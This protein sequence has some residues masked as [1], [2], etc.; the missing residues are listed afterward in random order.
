MANFAMREILQERMKLVGGITGDPTGNDAM[1][2]A[3]LDW[4][5]KHDREWCVAQADKAIADANERKAKMVEFFDL[6]SAKRMAAATQLCIVYVTKRQKNPRSVS[7]EEDFIK[8]EVCP[9]TG[10]SPEYARRELED[11]QQELLS[12]Q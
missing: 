6:D 2:E 9:L 11:A 3:A 5:M 7:S 12:H 10:V 1:E 4:L 8:K